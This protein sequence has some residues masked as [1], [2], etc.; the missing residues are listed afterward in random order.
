[1]NPANPIPP[2]ALAE[3]QTWIA[4]PESQAL[5]RAE[6]WKEAFARYKYLEIP[7]EPPFAPLNKPLAESRIA[8]ITSGGLYIDEEQTPFAATDVYGDPSIRL[9]PVET[10]YEK[11]KIAHDHYDHTVPEQDLSTI[12]PIR[13]LEAL[14]KTG[15]IKGL[16]PQQISYSGYIPD[17]QRTT[18]TLIPSVTQYLTDHRSE[19][20]AVLLVPV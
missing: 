19:L 4:D 2:N 11:L 3:L 18:Q 16:S 14:V 7:D 15:V 10:P 9:I 13:N 20:D 17:W 12:N 1:M 6:Q 8:V 5:L